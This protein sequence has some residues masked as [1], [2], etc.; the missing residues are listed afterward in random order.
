LHA[1][2][3]T[4]SSAIVDNDTFLFLKRTGGQTN[5]AAARTA[6]DAGRRRRG[7]FFVDGLQ[8]MNT[9]RPARDTLNLDGQADTDT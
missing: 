8:T 2:D 5:A 9:W 3:L 7:F 4:R 6:R 1:T